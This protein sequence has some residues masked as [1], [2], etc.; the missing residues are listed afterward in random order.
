MYAQHTT[1]QRYCRFSVSTEGQ[2][3]SSFRHLGSPLQ[4][5]HTLAAIAH[6]CRLEIS[7]Q[8]CS[9]RV[10]KHINMNAKAKFSQPS[11]GV[12]SLFAHTIQDTQ[13]LGTRKFTSTKKYVKKD[14]G[15]IDGIVGKD[16]DLEGFGDLIKRVKKEDVQVPSGAIRKH[17]MVRQIAG[18]SNR[19]DRKKG[20]DI[21]AL[22]DDAIENEPTDE[23]K[24]KARERAS[25]RKAAAEAPIPPKIVKTRATSFRDPQRQAN[26]QRDLTRKENAETAS[27][28]FE[29]DPDRNNASHQSGK[30]SAGVPA[31]S[32]CVVGNGANNEPA[33]KIR[34]KGQIEAETA[35]EAN[36]KFCLKTM[37]EEERIDQSVDASFLPSAIPLASGVPDGEL[38]EKINSIHLSPTKMDQEQNPSFVLSVLPASKVAPEIS[39]VIEGKTARATAEDDEFSVSISSVESDD[40]QSPEEVDKE[41]ILPIPSD[42]AEV[43]RAAGSTVE[44]KLQQDRI[45]E[46]WEAPNDKADPQNISSDFAGGGQI[47]SLDNTSSIEGMVVDEGSVSNIEDSS[48]DFDSTLDDNIS[49]EDP[50]GDA[51][52]ASTSSIEERRPFGLASDVLPQ[53]EAAVHSIPKGPISSQSFLDV[54][55]SSDGMRTSPLSSDIAQHLLTMIRETEKNIH[56]SEINAKLQ[57]A[58]LRNKF[59]RDKKSVSDEFEDK[60][61]LQRIINE[62]QDREHQKVLDEE[63][64]I[65]ENLRSE[66]KRLRATTEKIPRQIAE[67]KKTNASL[68]AANEEI[69]GHFKDLS[70]FAKKLQT[71]HDKLNASSQKCRDEYLPRYRAEVRERKMLIDAETKIKSMYKDCV[72]KIAKHV[73]ESRKVPTDFTK[74]IQEIILETASAVDPNLDPRILLASDSDSSSSSGSDSNSDSNSDSDSDRGK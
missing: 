20:I 64:K 74:A 25:A 4:P 17:K 8:P 18:R 59:E 16:E 38:K 28:G 27:D 19:G 33:W 7:S 9:F 3:Q 32:A 48:S 22:I 1:D 49:P 37:K 23:A 61:A 66:N 46:D 26:S 11:G 60:I 2:D 12:P 73:S 51:V 67:M 71:D 58:E 47:E 44:A 42:L 69:A 29:I 15:I 57:M 35:G 34:L 40:L 65:V 55:S 39:R 31:T 53:S 52:D 5:L 63:K 41:E 14:I 68:E 72:I 45:Q 24:E 43:V 56:S 54:Q 70:K 30:D 50:G 6:P 21:F 36:E 10:L 62:K 13:K